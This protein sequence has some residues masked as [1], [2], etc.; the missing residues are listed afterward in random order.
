[1]IGN[2]IPEDNLNVAF[3]QKETWRYRVLETE[4]SW[5]GKCETTIQTMEY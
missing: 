3:L 1:L 5:D 4:V 2:G